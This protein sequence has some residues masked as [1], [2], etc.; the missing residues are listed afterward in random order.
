MNRFY[1][2]VFTGLLFA[3]LMV[4]TNLL[5]FQ[6]EQRDLEKAYE[7]ADQTAQVQASRI[8]K[9][10]DDILY[11]SR[12]MEVFLTEGKGSIPNFPEIA[13]QVIGE[14][15]IRNIALA[16]RG[17][18]S[19]VYPL[20]GNYKA[21]GHNIFED[22]NRSY[23]SFEAQKSRTLTLSGP[24]ELIQ[25]GSGIIGRLPVYF[26]DTD[27]TDYF[28]GFI[29]VTINIPEVFDGAQMD[30]LEFHGY[31]YEI[32]LNHTQDGSRHTLLSSPQPL[33]PGARD[34]VIELPNA[35]WMLSVSPTGGWINKNT[36]YWRST[37][38]LALCL[39]LTL[40]FYYT[41]ELIMKKTE[42]ADTV[43]QQAANYEQLN[44]LNQELR[45]FRH[46]VSNHLLSLRDLLSNGEYPAANE[47][48][49]SMT[50]TLT[51]SKRLVNTKNYVFDAL[52]SQKTCGATQRGIRVETEI[53]IPGQL[54]IS[55][56]D[57]CALFGNALDNAIE[58]CEKLG[59]NSGTIWI[60]V[61]YVGTMLQAK[62]SNTAL[63]TP[64]QKGGLLST[65][66][67]D[68]LHHGIG[69]SSM[70][71]VVKKYHGAMETHYENGVFSLSFV[72]LNV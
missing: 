7:K 18:V 43:L 9:H 40:V 72:L 11:T 52:I 48:I 28:W 29:C 66:K 22:P 50:A 30:H 3:S 31:N 33:S 70:S 68:V 59:D 69:M 63:P 46:D 44:Q 58:A 56:T 13:S 4:I 19:Q 61:R 67:Q 32:W 21:L 47:Y 65:T 55:N 37:M 1:S 27:K 23:D 51:A 34:A 71:S 20:A 42:L 10:I 57:W 60:R 36:R 16:P 17:I 2:R 64:A 35:T 41:C 14:Y 12:T 45:E 6:I 26:N 24:Y 39:L 38:S 62:I 54:K 25:G 49:A 15:P 53:T 5:L 8:V